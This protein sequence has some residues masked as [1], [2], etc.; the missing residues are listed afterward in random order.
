MTSA[1][2]AFGWALA[3]AIAARTLPGP[4]SAVVVTAKE[5]GLVTFE[6]SDVSTAERLVSSRV[7]VAETTSLGWSGAP[8]TGAANVTGP[9][10]PI[11]TVANPRSVFPSPNPDGSADG[12][13]KI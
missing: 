4:S 9:P 8:S 5:Q 6:N 11:D 2:A 13:T 3:H 12:L 10:L 1:A 7:A